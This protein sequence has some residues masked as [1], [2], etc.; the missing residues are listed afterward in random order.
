MIFKNILISVK[1][2]TLKHT[3][4]LDHNQIYRMDDT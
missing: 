4:Q 2:L 1:E 3:N